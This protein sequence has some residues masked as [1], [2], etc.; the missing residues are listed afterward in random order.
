MASSGVNVLRYSALFAGAFYGLYRQSRLSVQSRI[1]E[2]DRKYRH[3]EQLIER[4]KAEYVKKTTPKDEMAADGGVISDPNDP[5]FDVE[6]YLTM[7][8]A[9]EAK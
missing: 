2:M 9:D 8:L 7:K 4:A 5:K 1:N 6:A 3:E